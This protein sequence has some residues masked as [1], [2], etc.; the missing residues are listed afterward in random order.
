MTTHTPQ[1]LASSPRTLFPIIH[2]V[3]LLLFAASCYNKYYILSGG[4]R[5]SSGLVTLVIDGNSKPRHRFIFG[6][7]RQPCES[8]IWQGSRGAG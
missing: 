6:W 7:A 3:E 2:L 4:D 1:K 8:V 5:G